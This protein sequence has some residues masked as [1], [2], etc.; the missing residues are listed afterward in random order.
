MTKKLTSYSLGPEAKGEV[1]YP[2]NEEASYIKYPCAFCLEPFFLVD[3]Y[4]H[5]AGGCIQREMLR[6]KTTNE[7][8]P[9][10]PVHGMCL[11]CVHDILRRQQQQRS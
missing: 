2:S 9:T 10:N 8:I 6:H 3:P 11:S 5:D 1:E 7:R 4:S